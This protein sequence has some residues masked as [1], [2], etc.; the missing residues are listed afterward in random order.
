[1]PNSPSP[2]KRRFSYLENRHV[3]D[4]LET[5]SR[6][7]GTDVAALVR[8]ATLA[9]YAAHQARP[10]SKPAQVSDAQRAAEKAAARR[11][12]ARRIA[13]RAVTPTAAQK[14][15]APLPA[16]AKVVNLWGALQ[17]RAS[18]R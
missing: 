17:R 9:Y 15:N 2:E 5:A 3:A 14:R 16:P 12:T 10:G 1:M 8:E 11:Q 7:R 18:Q 6:E 4:W 13:N